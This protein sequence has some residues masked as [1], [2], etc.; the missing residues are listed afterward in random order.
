[1]KWSYSGDF[2]C[3]KIKIIW[4]THA[5]RLHSVDMLTRNYPTV[6]EIVD[7]TVYDALRSPR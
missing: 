4:I 1:M 2:K 5:Q 6:A 7:R 3:F